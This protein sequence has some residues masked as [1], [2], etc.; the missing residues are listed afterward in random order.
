METYTINEIANTLNINAETVRR[1]VRSDQLKASKTSKKKG[2]CVTGVD[3]YNFLITKPK[4]YRMFYGDCS[5]D[6]SINVSP[7]FEELLRAYSDMLVTK[8]LI[9][10]ANGTIEL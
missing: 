10:L 3:L 4:Y 5:Q 1:W 7:E 9:A 6:R 8:F 2:Y